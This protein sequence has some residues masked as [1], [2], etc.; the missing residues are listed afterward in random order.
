MPCSSSGM[1]V[2]PLDTSLLSMSTALT[3]G[4]GM[5]IEGAGM[6]SPP[7]TAFSYSYYFSGIADGR[8]GSVASSSSL[9]GPSSTGSSPS[10][11]GLGL[12]GGISKG[13]RK[14]SK[15]SLNLGAINESEGNGNGRPPTSSTFGVT[16]L[17][18]KASR[19][20]SGS[21][22][23]KGL[24]DSTATGS[25]GSSSGSSTS[26]LTLASYIRDRALVPSSSSPSSNVDEKDREVKMERMEGR[27]ERV[28]SADTQASTG[29]DGVEGVYVP[30]L[31]SQRPHSSVPPHLPQNAPQNQRQQLVLDVT[32]SYP[33]PT[34]SEEHD[35]E[36]DSWYI[37]PA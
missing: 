20:G 19:S 22:K 24:R 36:R 29:S 25:S 17:K 6:A 35:R 33:F 13:S 2:E 12:K 37:P 9:L 4:M 7:G 10:R 30:L 34:D 18:P 15:P 3:S 5:G 23:G 31:L 14:S 32:D 8:K 27:M 28:G 1:G 26:T 16:H 11:L 21:G